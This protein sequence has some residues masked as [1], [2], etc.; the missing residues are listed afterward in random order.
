[1]FEAPE[2][3]SLMFFDHPE[4]AVSA[5]K[6]TEDDSGAVI[7]R[8]LN[9]GMQPTELGDLPSGWQVEIANGMEQP[10]GKATSSTMVPPQGLIALRMYK[11]RSK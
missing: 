11:T 6:T 4:L 2:C 10:I 8:L 5:I 3:F 1:L 9:S 7:F